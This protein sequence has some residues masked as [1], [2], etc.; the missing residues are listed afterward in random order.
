MENKKIT[1]NLYCVILMG[2]VLFLSL[3]CLYLLNDKYEWITNNK[4][5]NTI[6]NVI[7][8]TEEKE[9]KIN[10]LFYN[11]RAFLDEIGES[12]NIDFAKTLSPSEQTIKDTF[13]SK[14][15]P[16]NLSLENNIKLKTDSLLNQSSISSDDVYKLRREMILSA[17]SYN[18]A[19]GN[20]ANDTKG[21]ELFTI[22]TYQAPL[23]GY[24]YFDGI[25]GTYLIEVN[26]A[27]LYNVMKEKLTPSTRAYCILK[28]EVFK[29]NNSNYLYKD[30]G[31]GITWNEF[32]EVILLYD[33]Y[34]KKY[35]NETEVNKE[36]KTLF[37]IYI[38]IIE[39]PNTPIYENN[40]I[41]EEVLIT[42]KDIIDNH[43]D[44]TKYGELKNKYEND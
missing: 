1:K 8:E 4:V 42:Y 33:D 5:E 16:I 37:D 24:Y 3:F 25:E 11:Q 23:I 44:F 19:L 9:E 34:V 39:L 14:I 6:E 15:N 32:K 27:Y 21:Y 38:G 26:Y 20:L 29:Y 40:I 41:K 22:I 35:P 2:L 43:K 17:D 30:G 13:L 7:N 12:S 28:N 18:I 36:Y 31:L 10:D